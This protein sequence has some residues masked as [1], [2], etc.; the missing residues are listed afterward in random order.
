MQL[1]PKTNDTNRYDTNRYD[2]HE[3]FI[4]GR[5]QSKTI[6]LRIIRRWKVISKA[7]TLII[8]HVCSICDD[9][10]KLISSNPNEH[11]KN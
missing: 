3:C 11:K 7:V 4:C 5:H 8:D 2:V 6:S 1:D 10:H 9:K